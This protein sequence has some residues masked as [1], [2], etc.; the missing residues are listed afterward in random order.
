[1]SQLQSTYTIAAVEELVNDMSLNADGTLTQEQ[2]GGDETEKVTLS[3]R[4]EPR[5]SKPQML[6]IQSDG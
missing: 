1:M 6:Y 2:T 4:N 5:I 3:S